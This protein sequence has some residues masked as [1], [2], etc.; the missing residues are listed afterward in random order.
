MK[1]L[2]SSTSYYKTSLQD[3]IQF[4]ELDH[5]LEN[6]SSDSLPVGVV[7]IDHVY[8]CYRTTIFYTIQFLELGDITTIIFNLGIR[9]FPRKMVFRSLQISVVSIDHVGS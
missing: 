9:P 5:F 3:T 8:S 6:R 2:G 4:L 7:S 1:Y